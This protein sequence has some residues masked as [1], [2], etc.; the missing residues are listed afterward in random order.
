MAKKKEETLQIR[1]TW[2]MGCAI[3]V[4][5]D[6]GVWLAPLTGTGVFEASPNASL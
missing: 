6:G 2:N 4:E 3:I 5:T 1:Q